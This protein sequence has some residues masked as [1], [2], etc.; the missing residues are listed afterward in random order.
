MGRVM[1]KKKER[2]KTTKDPLS[3]FRGADGQI[4]LQSVAA[5]LG[6]IENALAYTESARDVCLAALRVARDREHVLQRRGSYSRHARRLDL[7]YGVIGL[8]QPD[9]TT[10]AVTGFARQ[11]VHTSAVRLRRLARKK[12]T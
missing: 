9:A 8:L 10:L 5:E 3:G 11:C 12:T 1:A 6:T 2:A 7:I 4:D